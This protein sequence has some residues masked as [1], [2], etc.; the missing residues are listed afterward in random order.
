MA[1][2][3]P[4]VSIVVPTLNEEQTLAGI[5]A[6]LRR[7]TVPHEVLVVDGGSEDGTVCLARRLDAR[8]LTSARGRAVQMNAGAEQAS[9]EWLCFFHADT[10]LPE[11]SIHALEEMVRSRRG[12]RAAVWRLV[13]D[14]PRLWARVVE[15]GA[16]VRDRAAGLPYGDQGLLV[17]RDLFD[18]VGGF[19]HLPV[20]EDVA[21]VR[22]I[23]RRTRLRR[24]SQPA[25]SSARRWE[26][27]G[28]A[29]TFLRNV[30][31]ALAFELGIPADRLARWH[32][33]EP[34]NETP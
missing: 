22:S 34:A 31:L 23:L 4:L 33:P 20:M 30:G 25:I 28:T 9:G 13:I 1:E 19:P 14:S 16:W 8:V 27:Q 2:L 15:T 11:S 7:L 10:R 6:D 18:E 26:R 24:F 32:R 29:W 21:I 5:L 17:R 12:P 3:S